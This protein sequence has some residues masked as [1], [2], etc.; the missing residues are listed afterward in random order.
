MAAANDV[1]I[2]TLRD[3]GLP[4]LADR[5]AAADASDALTPLAM[6]MDADWVVKSVMLGLGVASVLVWAIW[7]GKLVQIA[8]ASSRIG[9]DYRRL[10]GHGRLGAAP[11]PRG[12]LGRMQAAT[13]AEI[14]ASTG[15]PAAGV[16]DRVAMELTRIEGGAARAMQ[17]GV[18]V[19][20]SVG[21][22]APFIGLFG[23]VWGIMNAF[24]GIAASG[25]T[26]LAVVAPG[27]AEALLA[28]AIG[29]VAAIPAVL[30]FN[31]LTRA[32]G[33]Y[34]ARLGDAAALVER[35]LSRDLDRAAQAAPDGADVIP[36]AA[37]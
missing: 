2:S 3:W 15:L 19:I 10:T 7:A 24:V 8:R 17:S 29:L 16:K 11:A 20:G 18:T 25:T 37:E 27:I 35:T 23:T 14:A 12:E 26:N 22:T 32:I 5:L 9:R 33:G 36:L 28:T 6:F 21:S 4:A 31:H 1:L 13:L 34:R 30:L